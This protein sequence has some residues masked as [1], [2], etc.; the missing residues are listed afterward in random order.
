MFTAYSMVPNGLHGTGGK[1][2]LNLVCKIWQLSL[3]DSIPIQSLSLKNI[4][5]I[6]QD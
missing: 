5:A 3:Q 6:L 1:N 4:R 2:G